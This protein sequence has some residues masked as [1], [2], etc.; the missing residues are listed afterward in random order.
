[1]AEIDILRKL[2]FDTYERI[3][4][5]HQHNCIQ[6]EETITDLNLLEI[7]RL[8]FRSIRV[9]KPNKIKESKNGFDWEF[10]IGNYH[11]GWWRYA[12]QAKRLDLSNNRYNSLRHK[13][14]SVKQFQIDILDSFAKQNNSIPLYCFYNH[15]EEGIGRQFWHCNYP[16]EVE[17][18][19]C[20]VVP[21]HRVK[22]VHKPYKTKSFESIHKY[23]ESKPWQCLLCPNI[24]SNAHSKSQNPFLPKSYAISKYEELPRYI[25]MF[26]EIGEISE[27]PEEYYQSEFKTFPKRIMVFETEY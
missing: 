16:F 14:Q 26:L 9:D 1:M 18:L 10:W 22:L 6:S 25:E 11:S 8:N 4:L 13:V 5:G 24:I 7:K 20:T 23:S 2:A 12:I 21:L 17:Q 15:I 3:F 27:L 19:G